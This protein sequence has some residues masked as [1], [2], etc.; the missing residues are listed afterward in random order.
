[1]MFIYTSIATKWNY[2]ATN[3]PTIEMRFDSNSVATERNNVATKFGNNVA[4]LN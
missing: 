2:V 4:T 1:M 3:F